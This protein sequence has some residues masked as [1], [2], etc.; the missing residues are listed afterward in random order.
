MKILKIENDNGF[1]RL[2]EDSEWQPI[3]TIDKNGLLKLLD[4][5]LEKDVEMDSPENAS[6]NNQAHSIVYGSIHEKLNS[7][8]DDKMRFKDES[9]RLYL[10]EVSKYSN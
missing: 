7:L 6:I 4:M 3:D 10:D 2:Q 1:F 8:S 9:E 5:F